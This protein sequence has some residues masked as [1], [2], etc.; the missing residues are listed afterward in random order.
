[1]K[2]KTT[3][4][5]TI[6]VLMAVLTGCGSKEQVKTG[7]L[8]DY[9][10]LQ[11]ESKTAMVF[12]DKEALGKYDKFIIDP[13]Q[14][15]LYEDA[16]ISD[17]DLSLLRQ[18]IYRAVF[19]EIEKN[20]HV[21]RQPGHGVARFRIALTNLKESNVALNVIPQ[22]KLMGLGLGAASM[23]AELLDSIT[24]EQIGATVKSQSGN[25]FSLDGYSKWSDVKSIIDKWAKKLGKHLSES[26]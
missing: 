23:E 8:S 5:M 16:D 13:I 24:G 1:M 25:Q 10:K 4:L 11:V 19:N 6:C 3:F 9:S 18:Y 22:T 26:K 7:F 12:M 2:T 21:V 15:R 17:K 20:R 14:T